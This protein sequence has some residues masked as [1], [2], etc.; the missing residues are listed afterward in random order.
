[1]YW[2]KAVSKRSD[3]DL[4]PFITTW[5]RFYAIVLAWLVLLIFVF[6]LI[7]KHFE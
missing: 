4:P 1:M 3:P 2:L 7:T 6:W 5:N